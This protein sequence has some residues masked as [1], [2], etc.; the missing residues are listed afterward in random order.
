[1][2]KNN[3]KYLWFWE[4]VQ[5]WPFPLSQEYY[6]QQHR[7]NILF[8]FFLY[9]LYL[10]GRIRDVNMQYCKT[11]LKTN[12]CK[13]SLQMRRFLLQQIKHLEARFL[14]YIDNFK[15]C[16]ETDSYN[17]T[18]IED[19]ARKETK[20]CIGGSLDIGVHINQKEEK[21][22]FDYFLTIFKRFYDRKIDNYYISRFDLCKEFVVQNGNLICFPKMLRLLNRENIAVAIFKL[23]IQINKEIRAIITNDINNYKLNTDIISNASKGSIRST[24]NDIH[25]LHSAPKEEQD[26][27]QVLSID[28]QSLDICSPNS[29][30]DYIACANLLDVLVRRLHVVSTKHIHEEAIRK[31]LKEFAD[32]I[33]KMCTNSSTMLQADQI[34]RSFLKSMTILIEKMDT[35]RFTYADVSQRHTF[36]HYLTTDPV[37][38]AL[39]EMISA[40]EYSIMTHRQ[41]YKHAVEKLELLNDS[42]NKMSPLLS[43]RYSFRMVEYDDDTSP[44]TPKNEYK[45]VTFF[46][47]DLDKLIRDY[48]LK[49]NTVRDVSNTLIQNMIK[50]IKN[51]GNICYNIRSTIFN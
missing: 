33:D 46:H 12:M 40:A 22:R 36:T 14:L 44:K 26:G 30:M 19:F 49:Y 34:Q 2:N 18:E 20:F 10:A 1:M 5:L 9:K 24:E 15:R 4:E 35:L 45:I 23:Q 43:S 11:K 32:G 31:L 28:D 27:V 39:I 38:S 8:H 13:M 29:W 6:Y 51:P 50:K 37:D 7:V 16:Q 21:E 3:D 41:V 48:Q 47:D 25:L 42:N 17:I